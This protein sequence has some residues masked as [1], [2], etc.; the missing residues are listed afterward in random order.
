MAAA[1]DARRDS[2]PLGD[3]PADRFQIRDRRVHARDVLVRERSDFDL[4]GRNIGMK[5]SLNVG[6]AQ[7]AS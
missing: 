3:A 6:S 7:S 1:I 4:V 2:P 5:S